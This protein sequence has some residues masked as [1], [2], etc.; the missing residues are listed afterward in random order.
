MSRRFGAG[1]RHASQFLPPQPGRRSRGRERTAAGVSV[2][3]CESRDESSPGLL[4]DDA[5]AEGVDEIRRRA[6]SGGSEPSS[7]STISAGSPSRS[8]ARAAWRRVRRSGPTRS[9]A[10]TMIETAVGTALMVRRDDRTGRRRVFEQRPGGAARVQVPAAPRKGLEN[11]GA[12]PIDESVVGRTRVR[13][14]IH[15]G[16]DA[17]SR[18]V[19]GLRGETSRF[20][21]RAPIGIIVSNVVV[22]ERTP[23]RR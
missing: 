2:K 15:G 6:A 17:E 5:D 1:A 19:R 12:T 3:P 7:T 11:A 22:A 13:D 8:Q 14:A 16:S 20:E 4:P 23:A 10:G 21:R 9:N 18:A